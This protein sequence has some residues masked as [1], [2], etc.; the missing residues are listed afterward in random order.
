MEQVERGKG[1]LGVAFRL[2]FL[3]HSFYKMFTHFVCLLL[4]FGHIQ[5]HSGITPDSVLTNI[6]PGGVLE[7]HVPGTESGSA[8]CHQASYCYIISPTLKFLR[9]V[10]GGGGEGKCSTTGKK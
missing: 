8:V 4:F 6:T 1:P 2:S 10:T 9:H 5:L 3:W 7:E